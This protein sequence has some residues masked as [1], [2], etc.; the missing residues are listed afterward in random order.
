M[1]LYFS[2]K[3]GKKIENICIN[4]TSIEKKHFEEKKAVL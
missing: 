2:I 3:K 1:G 4:T